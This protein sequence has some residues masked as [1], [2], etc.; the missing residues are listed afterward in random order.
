[1]SLMKLDIKILNILADR[2][3]QCI[4]KDY[5]HGQEGLIPDK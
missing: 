5:V 1:M 4:K 3:Q 2:T